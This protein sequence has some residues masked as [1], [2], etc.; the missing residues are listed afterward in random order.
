M[1]EKLIK[2]KDGITTALGIISGSCFLFLG[3]VESVH[4]P[5]ADKTKT[6]LYSILAV[7]TVARGYLSGKGVEV[8]VHDIKENQ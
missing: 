3:Y 8:P 4:L 5:I 7:S 2:F 6:V 1:K